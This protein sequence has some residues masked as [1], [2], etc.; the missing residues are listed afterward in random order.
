VPITFELPA[1]IEQQL[2]GR[3]ADFDAVAKEAA[4][5]EL[6]RQGKLTRSPQGMPQFPGLGPGESAA[7]ALAQECQAAAILMDERDGTTQECFAPCNVR[8]L[9]GDRNSFISAM[10]RN[11]GSGGKKGYGWQRRWQRLLRSLGFINQRPR[12]E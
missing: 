1:A 3:W 11:G 9:H 6:Y 2:R 7:I 12:L 5:V 4:L 8:R 10:S